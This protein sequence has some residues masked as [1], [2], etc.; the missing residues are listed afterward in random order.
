MGAHLHDLA[1]R[2]Q[3]RRRVI[4]LVYQYDKKAERFDKGRIPKDQGQQRAEPVVTELPEYTT[5]I[6]YFFEEGHLQ[7]AGKTV[8]LRKYVGTF[9][10]TIST[11]R[12]KWRRKVSL[13]SGGYLKFEINLR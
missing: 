4:D 12:I 1:A 2:N 8:D 10:Q 5:G 9:S 7:K 13:T 6:G 11:L 3:R